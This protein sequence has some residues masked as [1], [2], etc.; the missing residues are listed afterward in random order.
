MAVEKK[1]PET[2]YLGPAFSQ[3]GEAL[4]AQTPPLPPSNLH[5]GG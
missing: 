3:D 4:R 5:Q 1:A 2:I